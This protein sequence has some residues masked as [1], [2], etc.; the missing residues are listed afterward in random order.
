MRIAKIDDAGSR[1]NRMRA[2]RGALDNHAVFH[3][4]QRLLHALQRSVQRTCGEGD[5][6]LKRYSKGNLCDCQGPPKGQNPGKSYPVI[7]YFRPL[8]L[9]F[10]FR[11]AC[12]RPQPGRE[13]ADTECY[14]CKLSRYFE[15]CVLHFPSSRAKLRFR[16]GVAQPGRAPGSGPGG[17]R[18]K[19]SLPDQISR[20]QSAHSRLMS[21]SGFPQV[22]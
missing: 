13:R 12:G 17:R 5:H 9:F 2:A 6:Q 15:V 7:R 11:R 22:A 8:R 14:N 4:K 10:H 19:S 20:S 16:R 1:R 3:Q 21:L 18:F